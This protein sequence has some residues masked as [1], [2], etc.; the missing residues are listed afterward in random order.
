LNIYVGNLPKTTS[1]EEIRKIFETHGEVGEIKLI[2]DHFSGELRGFGFVEMPS[3][4][5]AQTA[6]E[7]VNGTELEGR[8]LVVNEARQRSDRGGRGRQR[9]GGGGG[10]GG[11][12]GSRPRSW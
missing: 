8:T 3:N 11:H 9:G 6:I 4:T 1:E 12:R 7:A 10:G 2:K 5:D